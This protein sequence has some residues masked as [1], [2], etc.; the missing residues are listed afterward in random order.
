MRKAFAAAVLAAVMSCV[1]AGAAQAQTY[2]STWSAADMRK[3][4]TEMNYKINVDTV[5]NNAPVIAAE[6]PN[7]LKFQITGTACEGS[8]TALRCY[9][10]DLYASISWDTAA[11]AKTIFAKVDYA[12]VKY[13]MEDDKTIGVQRYLIFDEGIHRENLKANISVFTAITEQ[14]QGM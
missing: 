9:G 6:T 14:I 8:G 7:G 11:E 13:W 3:V 5:E 12:A 2:L 1:A 10:A 4:L